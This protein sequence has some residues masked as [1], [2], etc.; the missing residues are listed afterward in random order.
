MRADER[1]TVWI[2]RAWWKRVPGV[3]WRDA[4]R[5]VREERVEAFVVAWDLVAGTGPRTLALC[6]PGDPR[7]ADDRA[8]R[9]R[10]AYSNA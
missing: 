5:W 2:E 4:V 8:N 10:I 6:L 9:S 1:G 3:A 7:A